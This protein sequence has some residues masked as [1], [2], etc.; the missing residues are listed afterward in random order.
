MTKS[1]VFITAGDPLGIGPE[2]TVNA[3]KTPRIQRACRAVVI[4]EPSTLYK[5]GFTDK[6]AT[7]LPIPACEKLPAAPGPSAEGG[8]VSFQAVRTGIKLALSRHAPLITAPISK[9][10]WSLAGIPYTGHTDVLRELAGKNGLMSFFSGNL[11]IALA[12]EHVALHDLRRTLTKARVLRT[13]HTFINTLKQA[14][15]K[16]PH[17]L[18]CA[19]NPHASDNGKFGTEENAVLA[20]AVHTL[21]QNGCWVEGPLPADVAWAQH[22]RGNCDGL[23][24]MYH[25]QALLPLKLIAR[26]PIV[27]Y[28][29]GLSIVRTSPT[30]GTAFDIAGKQKADASS[31]QA[32]ILFALQH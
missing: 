10:S 1:L 26:Q 15:I 23:L 13:A 6:L 4:G 31:M 12:S 5:A 19:V 7:L 2:I 9:Q 16:Q 28:T 14:G 24:C 29:A 22:V 20:P 18:L 25:D 11:R 3:L 17:I 30:H 8:R 27:H 32:A 21:R